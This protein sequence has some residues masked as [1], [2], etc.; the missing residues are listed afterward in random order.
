MTARKK[1]LYGDI[2]FAL[3]AVLSNPAQSADEPP[4]S[5]AIGS[6]TNL[7]STVIF[8]H[9]LHVD[10]ADCSVCHHHT[11]GTKIIDQNCTRCHTAGGKQDAA[12]FNSGR[13]YTISCR[14]CHEKDR[15]ASFYLK[16]LENP[17][18]Y[19][20]DK[21]GLKGAYHLSCVGCHMETEGPIGCQECHTMTKAG[22]KLFNTGS[23]K[24][25]NS[26]AAK[27]HGH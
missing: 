22:E 6:I 14:D 23:F 11:T 26:Q 13:P 27:S 20:I 3:A 10:M 15:F 21:P 16:K 8:D 12:V 7:Y 18:L 9:L 17:K 4:E 1:M 5:V 24:P 19:H 2:V 25:K